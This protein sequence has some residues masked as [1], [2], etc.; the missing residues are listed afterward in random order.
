MSWVAY[1]ERDELERAMRQIENLEH[2]LKVEMESR[3]HLHK[4]LIQANVIIASL[5]KRLEEI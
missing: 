1:N 5:K 2:N 3:D 4:E